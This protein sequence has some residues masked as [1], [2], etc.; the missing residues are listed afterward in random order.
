M[1]YKKK[2]TGYPSQCP[3]TKIHNQNKFMT[4]IRMQS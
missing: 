4:A 1:R 3:T 2:D